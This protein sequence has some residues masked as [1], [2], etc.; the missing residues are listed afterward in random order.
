MF[1]T[2]YVIVINTEIDKCRIWYIV[3]LFIGDGVIRK[4][5]TKN[6]ITLNV[7]NIIWFNRKTLDALSF[8]F[9]SIV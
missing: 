2:F 6:Q 1:R 4:L 5:I 3:Y 8:A 7:N 9:D